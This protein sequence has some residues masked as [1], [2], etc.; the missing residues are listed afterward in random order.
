MSTS[1][2]S[3]Q[4][5]YQLSE[6]NKV[7]P[8]PFTLESMN[9]IV[10]AANAD[11]RKAI[12]EILSHKYNLDHKYSHAT[13]ADGIQRI[14]ER[15]TALSE[16]AAEKFLELDPEKASR[17]FFTI[18][19]QFR[20]PGII[21]KMIKNLPTGSSPFVEKWIDAIDGMNLGTSG[22]AEKTLKSMGTPA[23]KEILQRWEL[24]AIK[25]NYQHA[26]A[27]SAKGIATDLNKL[28]KIGTPEAVSQIVEISN[29]LHRVVTGVKALE[30]LRDKAVAEKRNDLEPY[31]KGIKTLLS[32]AISK[33]DQNPARAI[34][35]LGRDFK[36]LKKAFARHAERTHQENTAGPWL[37]QAR[38]VARLEARLAREKEALG[39]SLVKV[40]LG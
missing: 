30:E 18:A 17:N 23:A 31:D 19:R 37:D 35:T 22:L 8:G 11:P 21:D 7:R 13:L 39:D 5:Q 33:I 15:F 32:L 1:N 24:S 26:F 6:I 3:E 29:Q 34:E 38:H 36:G 20:D 40:N 4:T 14:A 16:Y 25:Y 2:L 10:R 12:D 9:R 28:K 27:V